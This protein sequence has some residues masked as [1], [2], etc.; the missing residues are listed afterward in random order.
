MDIKSFD[1]SNDAI[2]ISSA[3]D[4]YTYI[5]VDIIDEIMSTSAL[6]FLQF[7]TPMLTA[8]HTTLRQG[9][10]IP[11]RGRDVYLRAACDPDHN[12]EVVTVKIW[13]L[14]EGD[15]WAARGP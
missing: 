3:D 4:S 2:K 7:D 6:A 13:M 1:A 11:I 12:L 5:I 8:S 15:E 14:T 10:R 9:D